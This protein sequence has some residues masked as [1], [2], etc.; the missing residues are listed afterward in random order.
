MCY[1]YGPRYILKSKQHS[2]HLKLKMSVAPYPMN[3]DIV[4]SKPEFT[5]Q[6]YNMP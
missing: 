5:V 6:K 4:F 1:I 3:E 2:K